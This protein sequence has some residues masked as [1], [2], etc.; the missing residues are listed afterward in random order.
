MTGRFRALLIAV[1]CS[2]SMILAW[3]GAAVAGLV[4]LRKG[5]GEGLWVVLWA[6]LPALVLT[7]LTGDGSALALLLGTGLLAL[8]LRQSVNLSLT[9]LSTALVSVL[10]AFGLLWFGQD[11]LG[12]LA[13][14]FD[15]FLSNLEQQARQAGTEPVQLA[16]P[17]PFQLAGMMGVANGLLSFLC[18]ALARSWQ[19]EMYNPGGFGEEFRGL[20]IPPAVVFALALGALGVFSLGFEYRAWGAALLLPLAIGGFSLIHAR[21]RLRGQGRLWFTAIYLA[22]AVFDAAKLALIGLTVVDAVLDFRRRWQGPAASVAPADDGADSASADER[23]DRE[24]I[25]EG[26][27]DGHREANREEHREEHRAEKDDDK[28]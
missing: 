6:S 16:R 9:A 28:D 25:D 19:A 17:T 14:V 10:T 23:T 22:W 7:K 15:Q 8:V 3:M 4:M 5:P 2:G 11:L 26:H 13:R 18:L 20:R 27:D 1:A 12:E 24:D 21:A